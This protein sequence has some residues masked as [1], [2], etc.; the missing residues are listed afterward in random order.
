MASFATRD[1]VR[2]IRTY[3]PAQIAQLVDTSDDES[4]SGIEELDHDDQMDD[5]R[6]ERNEQYL[7]DRIRPWTLS[8]QG[9][10]ARNG[11]AIQTV[12]R[13]TLSKI[14]SKCM[15][16]LLYTSIQPTATLLEM[17]EILGTHPSWEHT[18][19][20][21]LANNPAVNRAFHA[22]RMSDDHEPAIQFRYV[23]LVTYIADAL[24]KPVIS[25]SEKSIAVG[26]ILVREELNVCGNTDPYFTNANGQQV[27]ASEAKTNGAFPPGRFWHCGYRAP[28][29]LASMYAH[30][31]PIVLF[32][33]M[34]YKFFF[35][36]DQRDM[37]YTFPAEQDPHAS[38]FLNASLMGPMGRDFL[39]AICICLLSPR[40]LC[41]QQPQLSD[42]AA[43]A[44]LKT[45]EP[46]RPLSRLANSAK[47]ACTQDKSSEQGANPSLKT[48]TPKF[49][50]GQCDGRN[51][52]RE[53]RVT[54]DEEAARIYRRIRAIDA[55]AATAAAAAA[56]AAAVSGAGGALA[57]QAA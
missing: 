32:T 46:R 36:S 12:E 33:Q 54:S 21:R 9:E 4:D 39:K 7:N 5:Q 38:R 11:L 24:D 31:C 47:R 40:F 48:V 22:L 43:R 57:D 55:Q 16:P 25:N 50:S 13:P 29:V 10:T 6:L 35:E 23:V 1:D 41:A 51:V 18:F 28:Q 26:G 30:G 37:V 42:V 8:L 52:Y 53:I 17:A 56:A 34:Q 15:H 27:L 3:E 49:V 20:T 45:P 2:P 44:T 14:S 19:E